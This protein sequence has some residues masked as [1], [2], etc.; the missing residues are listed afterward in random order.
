M[1][2]RKIVNKIVEDICDR[3]GIGDE[4]EAIDEDIREEIM[5]TWEK[6]IKKECEK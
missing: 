5:Q 6:I 3:G 2:I 4:W 1:N